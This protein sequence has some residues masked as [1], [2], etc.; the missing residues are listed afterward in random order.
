MLPTAFIPFFAASMGAAGALIGLLFIAISIAPERTV[1][2]TAPPERAALAGNAFTALTNV[3]FISFVGLIPRA[4]VGPVTVTLGILS[5]VATIRLTINLL[6]TSE[7]RKSLTPTRLVRRMSLVAASLVIYGL[8]IWQG[9]QMVWA[10]VRTNDAFANITILI[11]LVYGLALM[12]MWSL[13]GARKDSFFAWFNIL[14]DL[15][16]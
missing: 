2:K 6:W 9:G 10:G 11:V 14:N 8:E 3:F 7:G 5:C 12:R 13:L 4:T 1:G 16:Q 15:D